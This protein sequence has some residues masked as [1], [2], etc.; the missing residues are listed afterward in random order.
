MAGGQI[1]DFQLDQMSFQ[2][3]FQLIHLLLINYIPSDNFSAYK[4]D[5][6]YFLKYSSLLNF[7]VIPLDY[8]SFNLNKK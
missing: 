4:R 3:P 8:I 6:L 1:K 2:G 5:S 7:K